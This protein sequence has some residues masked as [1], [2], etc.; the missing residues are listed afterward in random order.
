M[1]RAVEGLGYE[2]STNVLTPNGSVQRGR[3]GLRLALTGGRQ[4]GHTQDLLA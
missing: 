4:S 2:V 1:L 3:P